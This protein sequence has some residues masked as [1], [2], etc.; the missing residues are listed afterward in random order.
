M[1]SEAEG[2]PAILETDFEG[3]MFPNG[4]SFESVEF[5]KKVNFKDAVFESA[6]LFDGA[7]FSGGLELRHATF[8]WHAGFYNAKFSGYAGFNETTF[9]D[10]VA[11]NRAI[12]SGDAGFYRAIFARYAGFDEATF[13][14]VGFDDAT[15][16]RGA[17]FHSTIFSGDA[18]FIDAKFAGS[19]K[20]GKATFSGGAWFSGAAFSGD[21]DFDEAKFAGAVDFDRSTF[22]RYAG[23]NKVTFSR[24]ARFNQATFS[25]HARFYDAKFLGDVEFGDAKFSEDAE[26]NDAKFSGNVNF[27]RTTFFGPFLLNDAIFSKNAGFVETRFLGGKDSKH[28]AFFDG[29]SFEGFLEFTRTEFASL[30]SFRGLRVAERGEVRFDGA[31]NMANVSLRNTL[32]DRFNFVDVVWGELADQRLSVLEH[33]YLGKE[34]FGEIIT[35]KHVYQV[36][37]RLR[38]N[39]ER[40][41]GRYSEAG[42]FFVGEMEMR[43]KALKV[44]GWGGTFERFLLWLFSGL[45]QYGESIV[46]P[47]LWAFFFIGL[48]TILRIASA[49]PQILLVPILRNQTQIL[50]RVEVAP[51][52]SNES[53]LRSVAAFFQLRSPDY[54]TD[55]FERIV[56]IP[57]LG[58]LFIALKRRLERKS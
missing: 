19:V 21:A 47:I 52:S 1:K 39:Y 40:H 25:W 35:A 3:F 30:T 49:E 55:A 54:W 34:L 8:L 28:F 51:I 10:S 13:S 29:S 31:I 17:G 36:Y 41:A 53:L 9:S 16:S 56:S 37:S 2:N 5:K 32:L 43:R 11:F 24:Y 18:D 58:T 57:I 20:F 15:F 33:R 7:T 6:I 14:G 45:S 48:F 50:T 12:F 38:R 44:R 27:K 26:F 42:D 22:S 4:I 46:R 23:F